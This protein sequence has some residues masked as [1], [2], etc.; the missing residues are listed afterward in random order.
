MSEVPLSGMG[1]Q[2]ALTELL[3]VDD[4]VGEQALDG[5]PA[6]VE[7]DLSQEEGESQPLNVP[8]S[9]LGPRTLCSDT[10]E[11]RPAKGPEVAV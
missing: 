7:F 10:S 5:D 4:A 2:A 9:V 6:D 3:G 8:L 11:A 1:R